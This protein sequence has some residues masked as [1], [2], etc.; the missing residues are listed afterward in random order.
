MPAT[1]NH[2]LSYK[3]VSN[4]FTFGNVWTTNEISVIFVLVNVIVVI[5]NVIAKD[6]FQAILNDIS[7]IYNVN[8]DI[9]TKFHTI[10]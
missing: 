4:G 3:A 8:N 7:N 1:Y 5:E 2:V 9:S 6:P 10:S